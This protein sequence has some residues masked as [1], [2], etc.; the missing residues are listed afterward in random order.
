MVV[1]LV[2]YPPDG[3]EFGNWSINNGT[4]GCIGLQCGSLSLK[5]FQS[6]ANSY[7]SRNGNIRLTVR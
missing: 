5:K 7:L 3:S 1:N 2:Q 4:N 6:F